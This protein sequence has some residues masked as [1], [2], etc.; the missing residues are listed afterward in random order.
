MNQKVDDSTSVDNPKTILTSLIKIKNEKKTLNSND[1]VSL[2]V[3]F[4]I[5]GVDTV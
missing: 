4:I 3:D 2:I 5:A 1:I